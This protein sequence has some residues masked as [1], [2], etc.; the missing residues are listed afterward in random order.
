[1]KTRFSAI[2]VLCIL[3]MVIIVQCKTEN[4]ISKPNLL[5]I[6]TDQQQASTLAAYGNDRIRTPNLNRFSQNA[7]VFRNAYVTQP[8]CS[9]SRAS[10]M[11][12]VYPH[13]HGVTENNIPLSKEVLVFPELMND[14]SYYTAYMGKWHLGDEIFNQRGF[15]EWAAI[16]DNIE[17]YSDERDRT[18]RSAYHHWLLDK[19][20][21]PDD[22]PRDTS[23]IGSV[24]GRGTAARLPL[25]H[26]K[27]KFLEEKA[28]DFLK[29]NQDRPFMLYI[30]FLEPHS[31]Y[32]GP[33]DSIH[34]PQEVYLPQSFH[35]IVTD[36]FHLRYL[37]KQQKYL[38]LDEEYYRDL[39]AKYWG[40]VTQVDLS[41]GAI[42]DEL[43]A[44]GYLT[45]QLLFIPV[46][47]ET[48]WER[49]NI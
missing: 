42:L 5:F 37:D 48:L 32:F 33:F 36:D 47:T 27:P 41:V 43:K 49:I 22:T 34:S 3:I 23:G 21:T 6:W 14:T 28:I 24:F 15:D 39:I 17:F 1:M 7:Y 20:Y 16:E 12:G 44:W 25:E 46:T 8:V 40:L 30:N 29:R 31:P 9:P 2:N 10:I 13:S 38:S 26:C 11:T 35:H 18:E 4:E 45:T 19:G